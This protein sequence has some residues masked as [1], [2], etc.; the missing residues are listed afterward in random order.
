MIRSAEQNFSDSQALTATAVSTNVIDLGAT[1]TVLG[2][3]T[4]LVRDIGKG[5]RIPISITMDVAAG[6]TSPTLVVTME[7]DDNVGFSSATVVATSTLIAGGAI[8]ERID[9]FDMPEGVS[10]QFVRLNYTLGG[11]SPTFTVS[12]SIVLADQTNDTV[13][14]A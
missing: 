9:L 13:A 3:P 5:L 7:V 10:E 4:T 1:G 8:G 6:G 12:S 14:G 11:T 2:A